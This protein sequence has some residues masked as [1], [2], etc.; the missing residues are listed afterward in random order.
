MHSSNHRTNTIIFST[1]PN[2]Q[3]DGPLTISV[4]VNSQKYKATLDTGAGASII[5]Y[6]IA[7]NIPSYTKK[8]FIL[9][10]ISNNPLVDKGFAIV[11]LQ[12]GNIS[13]EYPMLLVKNATCPIL[14][15][16][17]FIEHFNWP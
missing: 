11:K 12:I 17:D 5:D 15:G 10:D 3:N 1:T 9:R 7:K 4:H 16:Y 8:L 14:L 6:D 13:V 2:N